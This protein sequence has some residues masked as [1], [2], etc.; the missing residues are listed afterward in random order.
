[1]DQTM[2][3]KVAQY[4]QSLSM[5]RMTTLQKSFVKKV[6]QT[7]FY[8]FH[9]TMMYEYIDEDVETF[10]CSQKNFQPLLPDHY[11][12]LCCYLH[13]VCELSYTTGY[14][15]ISARSAHLKDRKA[16][17][18]NEIGSFLLFYGG[19]MEMEKL[20]QGFYQG[21]FG[22]SFAPVMAAAF[23]MEDETAIQCAK[24]V[25][26]SENNTGILTRDLII[27]IEMSQNE[28]L[29]DLL[30]QVFLAARLQEGLRQSVAETCD[31]YQYG[32]FV[33]T[34]QLIVKEDLIRYSSI[35]RAIM[36]WCGLGYVECKE[37]QIHHL[38]DRIACYVDHEEA[39]IQALQSENPL[40]IYMAFFVKGMQDV[41]QAKIEAIQCLQ[42]RQ[43]HIVASAIVYLKA[44]QSFESSQHLSLFT[45]HQDD[46]WIMALLYSSLQ[47]DL[48]TKPFQDEASAYAFMK[49]MEHFVQSMKTEQKFTCKGFDWY[50]QRL[51]RSTIVSAMAQ[52]THCYDTRQ[53]YDCWVPYA[54][55]ALYGDSLKRF[56]EQD[57]CHASREV[58]I[59]FL[60]KH[61]IANNETMQKLVKEYMIQMELKE[62]EI[63]QLEDR[64]K[65]KKS[66]AREQIVD[67]LAHQSKERIL[68]SYERLSKDSLTYRKE[69]ANELAKKTGIQT[70]EGNDQ[71]EVL[72]SMEEGLGLYDAAKTYD[73]NLSDI[74]RS[75]PRIKKKTGLF[76]TKE[77]IDLHTVYVWN[78]QKLKE[79][80]TTWS[81]R[82]IEHE[83]DE[84]YCYAGYVQLKDHFSCINYNTKG[85]KAYPFADLWEAYFKEDQLSSDELFAVLLALKGLKDQ[86]PFT[87]VIKDV[88][89]IC[90]LP[91]EFKQL[92]YLNII[93]CLFLAYAQE[94]FATDRIC[95]LQKAKLLMLAFCE[96]CVV[97]TYTQYDYQSQSIPVS[98]LFTDTMLWIRSI[99]EEHWENDEEFQEVFPILFACFNQYTR[100]SSKDI[101]MKYVPSP[102]M[103][104]KSVQLGLADHSLI[105]EVILC[106]Y[107]IEEKRSYYYGITRN[108]QIFEAYR[109]AYF[110]GYYHFHKKPIR[111]K[112][113]HEE[114]Y[115]GALP[116]LYDALDA[117][118]D[119]MLA[120]E[121]TRIN[122][123]TDVTDIITQLRAIYGVKPLIKML[124]A[125][126]KESFSRNRYGNDK[127]EILSNLVRITYPLESDHVELL[128]QANIPE[129]R[130][131]EVAMLSTQWI[132]LIDELL[133]WDGFKE[134]CYYFIAHMKE[135]SDDE[136][137]AEIARFTDLDP[138]DLRDGAFDMDW[139]REVYAKLGKK[140]FKLLYQASKFLCENSFHTRARKYADACLGI[141]KKD[142][143]WSIVKEKRNKDVLNAYAIIPLKDD[144]D[145]LERYMNIQQFAKESRQFGAQR[146]ASEKRCA[147][148]ALMNLAR[149]SRFETD[150]RL[151]WMMESSMVKQYE[152]YLKP[153]QI[154]EYTFL[155]SFDE[156]GKNK[157]QVSKNGKKLANVPAKLKKHPEVLEMQTIHNQWNEQYR[158]SK[159]MLE[160]AMEEQT[161]FSKEEIQVIM[162]NPIVSCMMKSLVLKQGTE[163]GFYD[164]GRL[165]GIMDSY[166]LASTLQIAHPYDLYEAGIWHDVQKYVFD[167]KMIQPFKQ[168]FRE[169]YLKL[170]D[171]LDQ[172]VSR[173]YSGYQ[174]HVKK[175]AGALKLRKWNLDYESGMERI[176]YKEDLIVSLWADADWFS[177]SDIEA[178]SIDYVAFHRRRTY[179]QVKIKDISPVI[180]SEIMRDLDLAVSVAY[181]GG[182][183]PIT[184]F[185]T[186]ELRSS[187]ISYTMELMKLT[188]V[189]VKD[190]HANIKG[191]LNDYSVHLGSGQVH[192]TLG[193]ALHIL[194]VHSQKRGKLYLPFLDEDPKTAEILSKIILLAEDH[195]LKDPTILSQIVRRA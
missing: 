113:Y 100:S 84:Y 119:R 15:R 194:S 73:S 80:V 152:Q 19:S 82:I 37:K 9:D 78:K 62:E 91:E 31:E 74:Q 148:I 137:K 170:D 36:T 12:A 85:L 101:T 115:H 185:S 147:Q 97:E 178:P 166:E 135:G 7:Y 45:M 106:S 176:Y 180:F 181:A 179:E 42:A 167:H 83:T 105:S 98:I 28:E 171:E 153:Q 96:N 69:A 124:H 41:D 165:Q 157:L 18:L 182:V 30:L 108:N 156:H 63:Y 14:V 117:I 40:D 139:C 57:L 187:I 60:M 65:T 111:I 103:V 43:R 150:T 99:L 20:I 188:N 128:K 29:Q 123:K 70:D 125:M 11:E 144:K 89:G 2:L 146:Q 51:H 110:G 61:I 5:L 177:P 121:C 141:S 94:R 93:E 136:K 159:R 75:L 191:S 64:L 154:E 149:N 151:A 145:L 88:E 53:F 17:L 92:P 1:M 168:V 143:L 140:R 3:E 34:L 155:I 35:Q 118:T 163:F 158:R 4:T 77:V 76:K 59:S 131:V 104:C 195:K 138:A 134:G 54:A 107:T 27:A 189:E 190:H 184:S 172:Y 87:K 21:M 192:Q 32:F 39:R 174:I 47:F 193:G 127:R 79:Y 72:Y 186:M 25:L 55:N 112:E 13:H 58:Q 46:P 142:E 126:G 169:L 130:W 71:K 102:L 160:T 114:R 44:V 56:M 164:Q 129:E 52:L 50:E 67:I 175:A 16:S 109:D 26:L 120:K 24:D 49:Q 90:E 132:D 161:L 183:D 48:S 33:K 38:L 95:F 22:V 10:L 81:N 8:S 66:S 68:Q 116:L 23:F 133:G 122:E 173:R 162:E 86:M 6:R